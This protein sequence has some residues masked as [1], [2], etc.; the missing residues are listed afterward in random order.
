MGLWLRFT[1][2]VNL[3]LTDKVQG[4]M[5]GQRQD[6]TAKKWG[7]EEAQRPSLGPS[8]CLLPLPS[9][10]LSICNNHNNRRIIRIFSL[11]T[12]Y[13]VRPYNKCFANFISSSQE[14]FKADIMI[15]LLNTTSTY[16]GAIYGELWDKWF[17]H[18]HGFEHKAVGVNCV[19]QPREEAGLS[20]QVPILSLIP[21]EFSTLISLLLHFQIFL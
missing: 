21:S 8:S 4:I 16:G 11:L 17:S 1:A 12:T 2:T 18:G 13:K 10:G 15:I 20:W 7:W 5:C 14:S 6:R 19:A 9:N 3:C